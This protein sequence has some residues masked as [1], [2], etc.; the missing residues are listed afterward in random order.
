MY[1]PVQT[2]LNRGIRYFESRI[3]YLMPRASET[4]PP[5]ATPRWK[6]STWG[7]RAT[8]LIKNSIYRGF[9]TEFVIVRD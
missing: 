1:S 5:A 9:R 8:L 4:E 3:L 7:I 2:L 6:L